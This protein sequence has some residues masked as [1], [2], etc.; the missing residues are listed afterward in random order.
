[1]K[2]SSKKDINDKDNVE[3]EYTA[4]SIL[5]IFLLL[6]RK[7]YLF[8]K[9]VVSFII[10]G[11]LVIIFSTEEFTSRATMIPDIEGDSPAGLNRIS[12]L[13]KT[14]GINIGNN[15]ENITADIYPDVITS[16]EVIYS[17]ITDS[18]S[19]N[20][21]KSKYTL[22]E[23]FAK[24]KG[25]FSKLIGFI[26]Q[27][28]K[29]DADLVL[30]QKAKDN[31]N[32]ILFSVDE[33]SAMQKF[34]QEMLTVDLDRK[35][36][37]LQIFLT[38]DNPELA[39]KVLATL[40]NHFIKRINF[41]YTQK[42][43]KN[44]EFIKE[45]FEQSKR[46][47]FKAENQLALFLTKNSDPQTANLKIELARLQRELEFKSQLFNEL[48]LELS[49]AEI[50]LEKS[51]PIITILEK[52]DQPQ[53]KSSPKSALL[54]ITHTML[55]LIFGIIVILYINYIENKKSNNIQFR[56]RWEEF[57]RNLDFIKKPSK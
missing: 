4:F 45:R 12:A 51:K 3:I 25:I 11:F 24:R 21:K 50:E 1:M 28:F 40:I 46:K 38:A 39:A 36:G 15:M 42:A 17:V 35:T 56:K 23:Y 31:D 27:I 53:K 55:G 52:P 9:I 37:K 54:L 43:A 5:D 16:R 33:L 34:K 20:Q 22:L 26:V 47:L 41:L 48:Q 10:L 18:F 6:I 29:S 57:S 7:K 19:L 30:K 13:G 8:L 14:F 44:H 32:T 2:D 49:K